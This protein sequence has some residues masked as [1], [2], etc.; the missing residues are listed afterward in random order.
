M[1]GRGGGSFGRG[2]VM[3]L[4]CAL[5]ALVS[6]PFPDVLGSCKI[7]HFLSGKDLLLFEFELPEHGSKTELTAHQILKGRVQR[8]RTGVFTQI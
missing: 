3:S 8:V 2:G 7:M 4:E 5:P 6:S 1:A